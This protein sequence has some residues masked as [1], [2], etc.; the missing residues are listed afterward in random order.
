MSVRDFGGQND[1]DLRLSFRKRGSAGRA[2]TKQSADA[3]SRPRAVDVS[4]PAHKDSAAGQTRTGTL[5]K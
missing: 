2:P 3:G 4:E 1:N 5:T